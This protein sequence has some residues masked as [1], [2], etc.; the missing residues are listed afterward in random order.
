[1]LVLFM[2]WWFFIGRVSQP[3]NGRLVEKEDVNYF[4]MLKIK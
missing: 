4:T 1:M 3:G 2:L